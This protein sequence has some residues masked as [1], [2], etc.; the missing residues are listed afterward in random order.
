[1]VGYE[2]GCGFS[3]MANN[4]QLF[5]PKLQENNYW[6]CVGSFHGHAH[7]QL[8]Q[9]DWHP[10]YISGSGLEDFEGCE[11]CFSQSNAI[12]LCTLH[13]S[14]LKQKQAIIQHFEC[15]KMDKYADLS[16]SSYKL[17]VGTFLNSSH[18]RHFLV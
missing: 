1:M 16:T 14:A 7:C 13:A 10:Q 8:C 11:W 17:F 15:W 2:I 12:A 3:V 18:H 4:S 9:L 5:G 6:F